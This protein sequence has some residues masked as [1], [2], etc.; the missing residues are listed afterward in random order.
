[1]AQK[2]TLAPIK[3]EAANGLKNDRGTIAMA[4]TNAPNSATCQF[5]I[6]VVDNAMLNYAGPGNAGYAVFGKVTEGMDVADAIVKVPTHSAGMQAD[7][8][9]EPII[10]ESVTVAE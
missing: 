7:I 2:P 10:I 6:N 1:M 5:F 4:R 9:N 3:N 8:P